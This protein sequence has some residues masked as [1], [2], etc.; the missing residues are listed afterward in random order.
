[1]DADTMTTN[2]KAS[3]Q[4]AA[5]LNLHNLRPESGAPIILGDRGAMAIWSLNSQCWVPA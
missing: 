4:L 1:M 3:V 5:T 2:T